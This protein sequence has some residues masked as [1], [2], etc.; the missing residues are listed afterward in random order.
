M[1]NNKN[2]NQKTSTGLDQNVAAMLSYIL[3]FITGIIFLVIE[4]ENKFVRFHAMQSIVVFGALF[5]IGFFIAWVPIIGA[6]IGALMSPITLVIWI[7][8]VMKSYKN[9]WY[10]F[11]IAGKIA[12]E[13]VEKINL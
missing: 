13:Q 1:D 10:E 3:G 9:E 5:V 6:L 7:I 11:P 12:K 2:K 8:L 4:K